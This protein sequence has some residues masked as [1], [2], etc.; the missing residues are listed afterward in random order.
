MREG[1]SVESRVWEYGGVGVGTKHS[2]FIC[3]NCM[4]SQR[5]CFVLPRSS[6]RSCTHRRRRGV[7][8]FRARTF[9][10]SARPSVRREGT[11]SAVESTLSLVQHLARLLRRVCSGNASR[12]CPEISCPCRVSVVISL[13]SLVVILLGLTSLLLEE[14]RVSRRTR[15]GVRILARLPVTKTVVLVADAIIEPGQVVVHVL[16]VRVQVM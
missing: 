11:L 7:R 12:L 6:H 15:I 14:A 9:S 3:R 4:R 2:R 5:E 1:V 16:V 13:H 8:R 10:P